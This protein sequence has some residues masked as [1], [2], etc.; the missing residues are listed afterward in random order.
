MTEIENFIGG[1][2]VQP[3]G[4]AR[5]TRT[6]PSR[7]DQTLVEYRL[8]GKT[9][10]G[11]AVDAAQAALTSWARTP[12][13]RRGAILR[14]AAAILRTRLSGYA[15]LLQ[16]EIA[17]TRGEAEGEVH[18]AANLFELYGNEANR[19]GGETLG[20]QNPSTHLY[21]ER[22][23]LGVVGLIT[24]WNYP[25]SIPAWKLAPAL[26]C[27]NTVVWKPS[28][29]HPRCSMAVIDLLRE[30]GLPDG[31]VN[32]VHGDGL[33]VGQAIVDHPGIEAISFT[34]SKA[35]GDRIYADA[36]ARQARVSC[37][38]GGKNALVVLPDADMAHAAQCAI[39]GGLSYGGQKCTGTDLVIVQKDA[40]E[41]FLPLLLEEIG[42]L[43][44]GDVFDEDT[45]FGPQVDR[46]QFER[47]AGRLE[48]AEREGASFLCGRE[49]IDPDR[50]IIPPTLLADV[51]P[52]SDIAQEEIFG[53]VMAVLDCDS[54]DDAIEI[55]NSTPYGFSASVCT[56]DL[57]AAFRFVDGVRTGL[58][59][60][61]RPTSGA[62]FH[63][64]FGGVKA[65][66]HGL[67]EQ[68]LKVLE[69]YSHWR[70]VAMQF[71]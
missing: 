47:V 71:A 31:V 63:A 13:T 39:N 67:T 30:A 22:R 2:F 28:L 62:E 15:D 11:A 68:G 6:N 40:R 44:I 48:R 60:V 21:T 32:L 65:S 35:T 66:G 17:K 41:T 20:S 24:P 61:N 27:G 23:P 18:A 54:L 50:L 55:A 19:Y 59:Y 57:N 10:V 38:M 43:G 69:F 4:D 70:T 14:S 37:E 26:L 5:Y 29:Q 25:I 52:A 36:G 58:A 51:D 12:V 53:P 64:P 56:N 7:P 9:D 34:G 8:S 46:A 49:G 33:P 3:G 1:Q 16:Q 42:K 45:F